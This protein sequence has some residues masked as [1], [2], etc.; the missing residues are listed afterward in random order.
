MV[1][2]PPYTLTLEQVWEAQTRRHLA[3]VD[4]LIPV[5]RL[6]DDELA[7]LVHVSMRS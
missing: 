3:L 2:V 5:L 4:Q 1:P 7:N 6:V